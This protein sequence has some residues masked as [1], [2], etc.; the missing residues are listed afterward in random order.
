M[1]MATESGTSHDYQNEVGLA[2]SHAY[3]VLGAKEIVDIRDNSKVRLVKIRNPWG[4]ED[5]HGNFSDKSDKWT[6]D[7]RTKAGAV[8]KNDGEFFMPIEDYHKYC[9]LTTANYNIDNWSRSS[10]LVLDDDNTEKREGG[11]C[12]N[13]CSYHKFTIKSATTQT[14][15]LKM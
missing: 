3:S 6:D 14:V 12:D 10:F 7:L 15:H 13:K 1:L 2:L 4:K 9:R 11:K 8:N 5:Y